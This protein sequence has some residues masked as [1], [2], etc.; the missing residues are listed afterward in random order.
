MNAVWVDLANLGYVLKAERQVQ[1][2]REKVKR[3]TYR[4]RPTRKVSKD[5]C[6][7]KTY[8]ELYV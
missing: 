8:G 4:G 1:E 2:L 7:Y 3:W 6:D 5:K